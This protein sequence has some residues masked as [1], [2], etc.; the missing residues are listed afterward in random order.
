M[1]FGARKASYRR[2]G[3]FTLVEVLAA[4]VFMAILIPVTMQAVQVANRAGQV[5]ERKAVAA[6]IAERVLNEMLVTG[7]VRQNSGNGRVEE[8]HRVYEWTMRSEPWREDQMSLVTVTVK[9]EVQGREY[10]V[11]LST[12]FDSTQQA[13]TQ[14]TQTQ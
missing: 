14:T 11:M 12:L 9:Y 3:A 1:R 8:R 2:L 13:T 10:D 6:R 4:L 5:G 7:G